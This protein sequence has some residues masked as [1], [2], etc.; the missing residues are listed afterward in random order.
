MRDNLKVFDFELSSADMTFDAFLQEHSGANLDVGEAQQQQ[1]KVPTDWL[2]VE[3][4]LAI[5]LH[6]AGRLP[7][8]F[9]VLFG[10][11]DSTDCMLDLFQSR[12]AEGR[13][14]IERL[15]AVVPT[16][17]VAVVEKF[18]L[19]QNIQPTAE[20]ATRTV[21]HHRTPSVSAPC[22]RGGAPTRAARP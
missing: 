18:L 16:Q 5:E 13:T 14:A 8:I 6:A 22:Q 7:T 4:V 12:D 15:P 11:T 1:Q 3:W 21:R 9:P 20:L 10:E 17:E 2:L 19:G